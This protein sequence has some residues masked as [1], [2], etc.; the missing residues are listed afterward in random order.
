MLAKGAGARV[1][2]KVGGEYHMRVIPKEMTRL[3]RVFP[4]RNIQILAIR[5]SLVPKGRR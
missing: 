1:Q 4:N 2:H 5:T 3:V